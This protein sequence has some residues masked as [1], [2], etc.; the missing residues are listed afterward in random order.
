MQWR[1]AVIVLA[2]NQFRMIFEQRFGR[3]QVALR[4]CCTQRRRTWPRP[5]EQSFEE[6]NHGVVLPRKAP[7]S[8]KSSLLPDLPDT[9]HRSGEH[10]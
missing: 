1:L 6:A 9:S 5:D 10:T 8:L 4:G 2:E 3:F 7:Y